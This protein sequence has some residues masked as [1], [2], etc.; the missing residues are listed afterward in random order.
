MTSY[1]GPLLEE[2]RDDMCS[3]MEDISNAPYAELLSVN[4]MRKGKGSY[5]LSLGRWR[6][7]TH[8]CGID[9]YKPKS[10][11]VLLISETKPAN[12]SD[13]LKQS[14]SCV[15]V[16]VSK[17]NGNKMTVKAL[18]V[19]ETGAQGDERRPIGANKYDKLYDEDLDK[20][21]EML[22]REAMTSKCRNSSVH[23]NVWKESHKVEKCRNLH[24]RNE[25][26]TGESKRWSFYAMYL[27]NM[28]TYDRVWVVLRRGLSMDSRI[29][30]SMLGRNNYVSF[31]VTMLDSMTSL[32][33]TRE[34]SFFH[35]IFRSCI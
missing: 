15:I 10:A 19:M 35:V 7:T 23:R 14:K 2:V 1:F 34:K 3:S 6:G 29:I 18:R 26:E 20:S 25:T 21:W 5:E 16:W 13:I 32:Q 31:S 33:C 11:D 4:S 27:T 28:V 8:G 17:V 9:N 30:R 22:D 24:G 12:P